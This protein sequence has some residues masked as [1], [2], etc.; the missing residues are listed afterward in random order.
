MCTARARR[1]LRSNYSI[2]D[3][4]GVGRT[5]R[6]RRNFTTDDKEVWGRQSEL[7]NMKGS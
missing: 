4:L 7:L 5:Y 6:A 1:S 3:V 2:A